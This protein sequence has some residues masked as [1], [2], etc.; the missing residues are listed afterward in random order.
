LICYICSHSCLARVFFISI[1]R[2]RYFLIILTNDDYVPFYQRIILMC[3]Y[4]SSF[5]PVNVTLP[6]RTCICKTNTTNTTTTITTHPTTRRQT[7]PYGALLFLFFTCPNYHMG[8]SFFIYIHSQLFLLPRSHFFFS[9][10]CPE[11]SNRRRRI[12][13]RDEHSTINKQENELTSAI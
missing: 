11:H 6:S 3:I 10:V 9:L 13:L 2:I 5:I 12:N 4:F 8:F 1:T 7:G